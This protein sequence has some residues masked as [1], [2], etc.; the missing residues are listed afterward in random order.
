MICLLFG[1]PAGSA[2]IGRF[3]AVSGQFPLTALGLTLHSGVVLP[4]VDLERSPE[5]DVRV[6]ALDQLFP[7]AEISLVGC[8]PPLR[9]C[10]YSTAGL[11][12]LLI[13]PFAATI[14]LGLP[15][16]ALL[17][18]FALQSLELGF[19]GGRSFRSGRRSSF[20]SRSPSGPHRFPLADQAPT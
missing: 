13:F 2:W 20:A 6:L 8:S 3:R 14:G 1:L 19:A 18:A 15:A 11:D 5:T 12:R 10:G 17:D 4:A 7:L 16:E 9:L